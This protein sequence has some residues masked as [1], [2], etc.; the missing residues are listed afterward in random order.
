MHLFISAKFSSNG[1]KEKKKKEKGFHKGHKEMS[2][3][4]NA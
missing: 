3:A 1:L 2:F 4:L